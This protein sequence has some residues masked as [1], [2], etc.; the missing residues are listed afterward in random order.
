MAAV[1]VSNLIGL[2][3]PL[4]R[5]LDIAL[6]VAHNGLENGQLL[7]ANAPTAVERGAL[8]RR[9]ADVEAVLAPCAAQ[10]IQP[11]LLKLFVAL[12]MRNG[13]GMDMQT[14]AAV[15]AEALAGLPQWAVNKACA[16]FREGRA[17]DKKWVPA[18]AELRLR[19]AHF[20]GP[21]QQ[22]RHR[23][24][25]VLNATV[26]DKPDRSRRAESVAQVRKEWGLGEL[27]KDI[28]GAS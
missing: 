21:W 19:A 11:D 26:V 1:T 17:G 5:A 24:S 14:R 28:A 4:S 15:Y 8:E 10:A 23:I 9:L 12:A 2:P 13:D 7:S 20:T 18:T 3:A 6:S 16:D 27:A 25:A 22:E